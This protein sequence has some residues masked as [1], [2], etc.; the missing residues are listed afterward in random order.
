MHYDVDV[1]A[2]E[3]ANVYADKMI[4]II[5]IVYVYIYLYMHEPKNEKWKSKIRIDIYNCGMKIENLSWQI[6]SNVIY[7][8][9]YMRW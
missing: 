8:Y 2:Y 3:C 6:E 9:I 7:I 5:V 4:M 1:S